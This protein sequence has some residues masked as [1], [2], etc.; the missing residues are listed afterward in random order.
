MFK[1]IKYLVI[2]LLVCS[3]SND[4]PSYDNWVE[5]LDNAI[6]LHEYYLGRGQGRVFFIKFEA[7]L[8]TVTQLVSDTCDMP[9]V[10]QNNPFPEFKMDE[11]KDW[12][13][14]YEPDTLLAQSCLKSGAGIEMG[15]IHDEV[16]EQSTVYIIIGIL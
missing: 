11:I 10:E 9:L 13:D 6:N 5:I 12:W 8:D 1:S 16:T 3:C 14:A 2:L 15:V 7:D 4:I